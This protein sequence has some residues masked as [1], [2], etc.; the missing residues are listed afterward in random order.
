MEEDD[1]SGS[2][3]QDDDDMEKQVDE[4][5]EKMDKNKDGKLSFEEI[6]S[7]VKSGME[8]DDDSGSAAEF[9][10][11]E[12]KLKERYPAADVDG[13]ALLDRQEALTLMRAFMDAD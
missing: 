4:A 7:E 1:D 2:A 3:A 11:F 5:M 9:A 10:E 12:A 6:H 8:E 13:D